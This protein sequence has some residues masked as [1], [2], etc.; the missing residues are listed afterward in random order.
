MMER[1]YS[2]ATSGLAVRREVN[3]PPGILQ[4][5]QE[6]GTGARITDKRTVQVEKT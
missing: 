4:G 6:A 3:I 1:R 2:I 5:R